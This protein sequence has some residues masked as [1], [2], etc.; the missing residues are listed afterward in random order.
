[1]KNNLQPELE[2][3]G[4][5]AGGG[6]MPFLVA[7]GIRDAN[8]RPVIAALD[9]YASQRLP[10]ECIADED[11]AWVG[12]TRIGQW[13]KHFRRHGVT[14]VVMI[15]YVHKRE[16]YH[17]WRLLKYIPD[18]R[19][20]LIWYCKVRRDKRDNS[21]L[22]ATA[23]ELAKEGITLVSDTLYAQQ[24]VAAAGVLTR[25]QPSSSVAADME[26]GWKIAKASAELD[27][28]QAIAVKERDI[29]AVE[30]V[31]GTDAMIQRAG[32]L[33]KS[34]GWTMIKVAR[35]NQDM[36]F[37][38]PTIGPATVKNLVAAGCA[39]LVVQ[40]DKTMIADMPQTLEL[41]DKLGLVIVGHNGK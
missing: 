13:I 23:E 1:M 6:R 33:C 25:R 20:A 3:I 2:K 9:G 29:I 11:F 35:P 5:I 36:R 17:R 18:L 22:L 12:L 26:F 38:V 34:G 28:G 7:R 32:S 40:A 21:V 15:G 16:M 31:E 37:D 39:C 8:G 27:I 24:H 10:G 19:T 14:Q 30:A 4:I 41:A